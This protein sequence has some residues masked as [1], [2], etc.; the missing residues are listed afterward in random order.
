M[1]YQK[2][3]MYTNKLLWIIVKLQKYFFLTQREVLCPNRNVPF[4]GDITLYQIQ[5][6][7]FYVEFYRFV[8][9][10][11]NTYIII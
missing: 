3:H 2:P 11:N 5:S 7:F 4:T 9:D 6:I 8:L 1:L 10:E